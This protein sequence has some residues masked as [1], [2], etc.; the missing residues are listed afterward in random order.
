MPC[1]GEGHLDIY[2]YKIYINWVPK[3]KTFLFMRYS[4]IL[5]CNSFIWG[6]PEDDK[7]ENYCTGPLLTCC[8]FICSHLC[9]YDLLL[10]RRL[11]PCSGGSAS[12]SVDNSRVCST[13]AW[14]SRCWRGLVL[15]GNVRYCGFPY[16]H[17]WLPTPTY[18]IYM[19][20]Y[21]ALWTCRNTQVF[22]WEC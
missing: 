21:E 18:C 17:N 8:V 15:I 10:I 9:W 20:L 19:Y 16:I 4:E 1:Y 22:V 12:W 2:W 13:V 5:I 7:R 11:C 14:W 3:V 6:T